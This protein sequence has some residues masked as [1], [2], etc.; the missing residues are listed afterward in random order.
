M[1]IKNICTKLI[2]GLLLSLIIFYPLTSVHVKAQAAN[3]GN[4][5]NTTNPGNTTNTTNPGNTTN[6]TNPGINPLKVDDLTTFVLQLMKWLLGTIGVVAV[7]FIM[8]GGFKMITAQGNEEAVGAAKKTIT[9]AII[10]L[11]VAILSFSM[12]AIVENLLQSNIKQVEPTQT[13]TSK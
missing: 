9:W 8:I 2:L 5:T 11:V 6:T 12:I 7:L 3:P 13:S 4:T 10:G 1:K